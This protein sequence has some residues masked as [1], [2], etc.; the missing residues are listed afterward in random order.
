MTYRLGLSPCPNDTFLFDALLSGG[1]PFPEPIEPVFGDVEDLNQRAFRGEL[2]VT[3]LSFHAAF[4]VQD[5]YAI[6]RSGSA[7]G[8]GCGPLVVTRDPKLELRDLA[9]AKVATPGE[10]TTAALLLRL[11]APEH[12]ARVS[13]PFDQV[14][15]AL[16]Q[17]E[18]QAG[19][20]IHELRFTYQ[21][22]GYRSLVDLG[23]WWERETGC[24]IPLGCI[25][26]KRSLG[27]KRHRE[28]EAA[29]RES[30]QRAFQNPKAAQPRMAAHAQE[31]DPEVM[32]KHVELYVNPFTL[33]LGPEGTQA[34]R[35]LGERARAAGMLT[36]DPGE[37]FLD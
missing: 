19:L 4:L 12:D 2:E 13:L 15:P 22:L 26:A 11:F 27:P 7:L 31:M 36:R 24:P 35:V 16:D 8:H 1:I 28:L 37:L 10:H 34:V 25:V 21:D 5:E 9:A 6:L 18:A 17:G 33:D 32:Q 29:I 20:I 3:K 23:D 30:T 14:L